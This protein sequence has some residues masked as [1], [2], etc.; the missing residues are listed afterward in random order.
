MLN[1]ARVFRRVYSPLNVLLLLGRFLQK[2]AIRTISLTAVAVWTVLYKSADSVM[3][4]I[5]GSQRLALVELILPHMSTLALTLGLMFPIGLILTFVHNAIA[6]NLERRAR[7]N[8]LM[9]TGDF[10]KCV[11]IE[12]YL[13]QLWREVY[14]PEQDVNPHMLVDNEAD[15]VRAATV[16]INTAQP[17]TVQ[18]QR[19]GFPLLLAES[20]TR[21]GLFTTED[22][23]ADLV[24]FHQTLRDLRWLRYAAWQRELLS[25]VRGD[26]QPPFWHSFTVRKF[27]LLVGGYLA[28][29][30]QA[31]ASSSNNFQGW[32][33]RAEFFIWQ[34]AEME[35]V[36][37]QNYGAELVAE[38][39]RE[40]K[41]IFR[42]VFGDD[43]IQARQQLFWMF[44]RDYQSTLNLRLSF[45]PWYVL[46][47]GLEDECF[48]VQKT[49]GSALIKPKKLQVLQASARESR[50]IQAEWLTKGWLHSEERLFRRVVWVALHANLFG[51]HKLKTDDEFQVRIWISNLR[52]HLPRISRGLRK[53]REIHVLAKHQL[54]VYEAIVLEMGEYDVIDADDTEAVSPA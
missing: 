3:S 32:F 45:D 52:E 17:Q 36:L 35:K 20:W 54:D 19:L 50:H 22:H 4:V 40:R 6:I 25:L 26:P 38:L 14:Q 2:R 53:I 34:H 37:V 48:D 10:K 7:V 28:K 8:N 21:R 16:A 41:S 43:K 39:K 27:K 44:K 1:A 24:E 47:G 23:L 51:A 9:L 49:Y 13:K 33:I 5:S 42:R 15:F 31:D 30:N 11:L 12:P 29:L 46:H 18:E